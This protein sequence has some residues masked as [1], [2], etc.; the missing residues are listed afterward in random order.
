MIVMV[1]GVGR[2]VLQPK[3]FEQ[4]TVNLKNQLLLLC[5]FPSSE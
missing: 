5:S 3:A 2:F 4:S 1:K